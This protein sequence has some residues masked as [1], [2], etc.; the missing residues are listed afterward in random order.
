M[1]YKTYNEQI[2]EHIQFLRGHGLDV[3]D[4]SIDEGFVRC[5]ELERTV[6][7]GELSYKATSNSLE[8]GLYGLATW[9]RGSEGERA[10]YQ[11]YGEAPD[12]EPSFLQTLDSS[13]ASRASEFSNTQHEEAARKAYGFWEHSLIDG[14]SDYLKHKKVGY[15]GIRF[16][17]TLQYGNVAVVPMYDRHS[18]IW[19]YQLLNPDGS[20]RDAKGARTTGLSFFLRPFLNGHII[21]LAESYVTAAT[22]MEISGVPCACCFGCNNL[23]EVAE[24]FA[25]EYPDSQLVIFADNDRHLE[26]NQGVLKATEAQEALKG[27][28]TVAVPDF[29]NIGPS[30]EAGD[31]NDLLL[32]KGKAEVEAQIGVSWADRVH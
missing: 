24:L 10:S 5:R 27:R 25:D 4:L 2:T 26:S 18:R 13:A 6:G 11:T 8:N 28:V 12:G 29:G 30:K 14:E 22:S 3:E 7:R 1:P 32:L 16:R 31:W 23:K 17:K 20:K 19:N 9:C 21:G 15:Y